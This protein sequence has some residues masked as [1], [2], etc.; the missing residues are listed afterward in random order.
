MAFY[1]LFANSIL[2]DRCQVWLFYYV[3]PQTA[4]CMIMTMKNVGKMK[5]TECFKIQVFSADSLDLGEIN[6]GRHLVS[7]RNDRFN[8]LHDPVIIE[9]DPFLFV[10]HNRLYLFYEH[11]TLFQNGVIMMT[12]T[13]DLETWEKPC[14][15]LQE[16]CHLSYP[17]VF[18]YNDKVYMIPETCRMRSIRLYCAEN[19]TLKHFKYQ[20]T[21]LEENTNPNYRMSYSDTS[22]YKN[23]HKYYLFTTIREE[24]GINTLKL[25]VADSLT[26]KYIE[27]VCSPISVSNKFGRNAGNIFLYQ[28]RIFRPCQ[29]CDNSYGENVHIQH[30]EKLSKE[31]YSESSYKQNVINRD[32]TFFT[33]GG[34]QFS[35]V[36]FRNQ[37][38]V[39]TDAK[40]YHYFFINKLI[41]KLH[42]YAEK[43]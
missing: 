9:A 10:Y 37:Y 40:E 15:V 4:C 38:I 21:L 7:I 27:H 41:N 20:M 18:A 14:C 33:D 8:P 1:H 31:E 3:K 13:N 12:S 6:K 17:W 25:Y 39:A 19:D 22:I 28:G 32:T 24:D 34:H 2:H 35:W 42:L 43:E 11:K 36:F 29:D 26:G 30:I 23:G 16:K 5:R